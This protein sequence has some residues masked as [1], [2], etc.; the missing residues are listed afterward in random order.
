MCRW[1]IY[2]FRK[3]FLVCKCENMAGFGYC[4]RCRKYKYPQRIRWCRVSKE[5][6]KRRKGFWNKAKRR[7][8]LTRTREQTNATARRY[9]ESHPQMREHYKDYR[10][11]KR[12]KF[13]LTYKKGKCCELCG[14]KEYPE[15]IQFHH[16]NRKGNCLANRK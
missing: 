2:Q 13:I 9:L 16:K 7:D 15:I 14:Y 5:E 4:W 8:Y 3:H 12:Q 6:R 10:K 1:L 11:E